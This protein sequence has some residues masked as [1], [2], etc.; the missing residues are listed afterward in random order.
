MRGFAGFH[1]TV[2][3]AERNGRGLGPEPRKFI[4]ANFDALCN[5]RV[6][7]VQKRNETRDNSVL[8]KV[9]A[10]LCLGAVLCSVRECLFKAG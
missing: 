5:S 9:L 6:A 2:A 8:V 10:F 7:E 4:L 1:S 3:E